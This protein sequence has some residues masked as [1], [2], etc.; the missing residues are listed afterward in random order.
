MS[1]NWHFVF[2]IWN[3]QSETLGS[4][5]NIEKLQIYETFHQMFALTRTKLRVSQFQTYRISG[6]TPVI[7]F[8]MLLSD[9]LSNP[10]SVVWETYI[11]DKLERRRF[12]EL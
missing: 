5:L 6:E 10:G 1:Y 12:L 11:S 9:P 3:K 2:I 7:R 4:K 8:S